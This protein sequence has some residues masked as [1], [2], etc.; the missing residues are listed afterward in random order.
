M[1][2]VGD[3]I[4]DDILQEDLK[5]RYGKH[6][7]SLHKYLENTPGLLVDEPTDPFD[8][9]PPCKSTDSRLGDALLIHNSAKIFKVQNALPEY[10]PSTPCD[11]F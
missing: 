4:A 1:L 8:A 2:G 5:K 6:N 7:P 11:V 10:C 9:T 3:S